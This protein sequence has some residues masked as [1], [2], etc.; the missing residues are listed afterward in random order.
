MRSIAIAIAGNPNSGK[1]TLFNA[2]TGS[3]Q[4][5]ANWA[6][7]TVE[8][9]SG[10]HRAGDQ[11][12]QIIDLPGTYSLMARSPEEI[13]ARDFLVHERPAA[14]IDV[15]DAAN[16]ERNLLLTLQLIELRLPLIVALNM[17]DVA[18]GRGQRIDAAALARRL[19]VPV[20]ETVARS[21]KGLAEL[22]QAA[23]ACAQAGPNGAIA[24]QYGAELESAIGRIRAGLL[25]DS[26]L[27]ALTADGGGPYPARC[28][29]LH[30]LQG[31]SALEARVASAAHNGLLALLVG[32]REQLEA[33]LG[34]APSEAVADQLF[35]QASSIGAA[36]LDRSAEQTRTLSDR[37]DHFLTH[38]W[39]GIPIFLA[40]LWSVFQ[41]T[42]S[43]A[44]APQ[45]W[46]D[47]GFAAAAEGVRALVP[48]PLLQSLL[49]DGVIA[50]VGMTMTFLP[51]ILILFFLI[52]LM[53]DSGYMARVAFLMDRLMRT[54]GLH[55]KAFLSLFTG[56][57]CN[58]PAI[59]STRTLEHRRDRMVTILVLPFMSC[60]ARYQVYVLFC[61]AF[62][63]SHAA[64]VTLSLYLISVAV[65]LGIGRLLRRSLF[66][67]GGAPFVLELPPY[68]L[69]T[70]RGLW[71]HTWHKARAFVQRVGTVILFGVV[72]VWGLYTF[73]RQV[74]LSR[75]FEHEIAALE[76][77]AQGAA[78]GRARALGRRADELRIA[79]QQEQ[80]EGRYAGRFGK[81]IE[82]ALRPLGLDWR[83]GVSLIPGFVAKEITVG[84]MAVLYGAAASSDQVEDAGIHSRLVRKLRATGGF[85]PLA[86]YTFLVFTLLYI[87]CLSTVG[88]IQKETGS[89]GWAGFS[90]LVSLALGYAVAFTVYRAGTWLGLGQ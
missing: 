47:A 40:L 64:T 12:L 32:Q 69:P 73:P 86:A 71:I 70:L 23:I 9:K 38:R 21:G 90:I 25:E 7:V 87:P 58:V 3:H 84:S 61:A 63:A 76:S 10:T 41:L 55:G 35:A 85:T 20:V 27:R 6:G 22:V 88:V 57:G 75:D 16:L 19:G 42:Y 67:G 30:L 1:T 17:V 29:A 11:T 74:P 43:A 83:I 66:P 15:V 54:M 89:W 49:V 24:P 60:S 78:P 62:F 46:I 4:K 81:W 36:A 65:A 48:L 31:D 56:F 28:L 33:A 51:Q 39:L 18:R 72:V 50:G 26:G 45:G 2:L 5:V 52:A 79:L 53:E 68:R 77:A 34:E 14:V 37:L 80:I 59:L 44:K 8:K 82:P 13:L